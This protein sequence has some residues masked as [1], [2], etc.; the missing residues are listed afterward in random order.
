MTYQNISAMTWKGKRAMA[1][2]ALSVMRSTVR[3]ARFTAASM[4]PARSM[5]RAVTAER[6]DSHDSGS[7]R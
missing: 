3:S 4:L 2:T 7:N 5:R 1:T 6:I